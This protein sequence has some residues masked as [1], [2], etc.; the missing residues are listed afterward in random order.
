[1][2]LNAIVLH[3]P[4]A[5]RNQKEAVRLLAN[6]SKELREAGL[7]A[8]ERV[9][10]WVLA[11][12]PS[13][14]KGPEPFLWNGVD[15]LLKMTDDLDFVSRQLG[16]KA[17][18]VGNF[19]DGNPLLLSAEELAGRGPRARA[20]RVRAASL[21]LLDVLR[22]NGSIPEVSSSALPPPSVAL[23]PRQPSRKGNSSPRMENSPRL[24]SSLSEGKN[25][26]FPL[27]TSIGTSDRA[28][29]LTSKRTLDRQQ[30]GMQPGVDIAKPSNENTTPPK[31]GSKETRGQSLGGSADPPSPVSR[32]DDDSILA[33]SHKLPPTT[34]PMP[35]SSSIT[36]QPQETTSPGPVEES[37][38]APSKATPPKGS[39]IA[40]KIEE[41]PGEEEKIAPD[42]GE[43]HV[44]PNEKAVPLEVPPEAVAVDAGL[45]SY[46]EETAQKEE[47][48]I[49]EDSAYED[50]E[51]EEE[52]EDME[53][54]EDEK[55]EETVPENVSSSGGGFS[56]WEQLRQLGEGNYG[57]VFEVNP[58]NISTP[59][60]LTFF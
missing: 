12:S 60:P 17:W 35:P 9:V 52:E 7:M 22:R 40:L 48:E 54:D 59:T 50:D 23:P 5:G 41:R 16:A 31:S 37:T 25:H 8:V 36:S 47:I 2:Q 43:D 38:P 27:A 28:K 44:A 21:V 39:S 30:D 11:A 56:E 42:E 58:S 46:K 57:D 20:S 18:T 26:S 45:E 3:W 14:A 53:Q 24:P 34:T 49:N 32:V 55:S 10:A 4:A 29:P 13:A 1:M 19:C 33:D 6:L 51:Y 15:Y